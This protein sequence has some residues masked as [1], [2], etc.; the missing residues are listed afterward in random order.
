MSRVA[1]LNLSDGTED[2]SDF[3]DI[4]YKFEPT[5]FEQ[6]M[7]GFEPANNFERNLALGVL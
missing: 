5:R 7:A 1:Q 3:D 2:A 4:L 6:V